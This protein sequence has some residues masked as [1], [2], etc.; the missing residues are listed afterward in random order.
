MKLAAALTSHAA[1]QAGPTGIPDTLSAATSLLQHGS[2]LPAYRSA[3]E[4]KAAQRAAA[5]S[6]ALTVQKARCLVSF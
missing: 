2:S 3:A 5:N 4:D 1:Q 6:S